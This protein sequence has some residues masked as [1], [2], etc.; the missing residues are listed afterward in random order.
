MTENRSSDRSRIIFVS[1]L[2]DP[3][4]TVKGARFVNAL[5]QCGYEVEALTGFP[6][7]P[8]GSVYPGYKIR[9]IKREI[10]KGT[11]VTRVLIYPSHDKNAIKRLFCYFSFFCL[12]GSI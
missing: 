5:Q 12:P 10:I 7:Y 3:E 6:N 9:P 2:Y 11:N 1:Q 8:G 4:P